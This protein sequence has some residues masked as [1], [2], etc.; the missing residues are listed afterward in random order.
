MKPLITGASAPSCEG[1]H[2]DYYTKDLDS[3]DWADSITVD[4]GDL[5]YELRSTSTAFVCATARRLRLPITRGRPDVVLSAV[6]PRTTSAGNST[7][8]LYEGPR[9]VVR[10]LSTGTLMESIL[11]ELRSR[12]LI[13]ASDRIY[14]N[15]RLISGLGI[16]VLVPWL[17]SND[18]VNVEHAAARFGIRLASSGALV[19]DLRHGRP[20]NQFRSLGRGIVHSSKESIDAIATQ[21]G[22]GSSPLKEEALAEL[23]G[24]TLN[25]RT[26]GTRG[27]W[28][29]RAFVEQTSVIACD[30][31]QSYRALETLLRV[32]TSMSRNGLRTHQVSPS[33]TTWRVE[34]V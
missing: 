15:A 9:M 8:E 10:T 30:G 33:R 17:E 24:H 14:I 22:S 27:L 23:A 20:V 34:S 18:L 26:V 13:H 28:A 29:L 16:R 5:R 19:L 21:V 6:I 2:S 4:L 3:L 32:A 11:D 25:L 31:S 7:L 12:A 1:D